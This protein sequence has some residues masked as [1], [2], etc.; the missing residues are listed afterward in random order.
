MDRIVIMGALTGA[1][2]RIGNFVNS[3]MEGTR[4][5]SDTGIVYAGFTRDYLSLDKD[6]EDV[7][8]IKGGDFKSETPGLEPV[9]VKIE[10]KPGVN[11]IKKQRSIEGSVRQDLQTLPEVVQ[12]IDF[13]T[14][15]PLAYKTYMDR[16]NVIVEIHGI[17][18]VRHAGQ[19]YEAAYCV[20]LFI[21]LF[22][23]WN[24]R[25]EILPAGFNFA[26]FMIVLWSL[27]FVDEFFKM[28]QEAY[29]DQM[30][31]N[32]GQWLSIPMAIV[33]VVLMVWIYKRGKTTMAE[34]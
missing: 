9:I 32:M 26:L 6:V 19:L 34:G 21:L 33:G 10:Y 22:W 23:L 7:S 24:K 15:E 16:G 5:F 25:R 29:E 27:R 18:I 12:H 28:N 3:E 13:G 1:L 14:R 2:I 4:T 31:L 8:F 20:A 30:T 11:V 17:G